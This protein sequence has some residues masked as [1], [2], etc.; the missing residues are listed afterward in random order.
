MSEYNLPRFDPNISNLILF[1]PIV[2]DNFSN[3]TKPDVNIRSGLYNLVK[4]NYKNIIYLILVIYLYRQY[5]N[6]LN[7]KYCQLQ[8]K[9]LHTH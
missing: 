5:Y 8:L 4:S 2:L 6:I 9:Y 7:K 1:S 3:E